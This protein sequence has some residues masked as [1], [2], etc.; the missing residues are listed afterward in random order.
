MLTF[1]EIQQFSSEAAINFTLNLTAEERTRSRHRFVSEEGENVCL[2]LPRGV[3]LQDGDILQDDTQTYLA[4]VIAKPEQVLT[5]YA[6]QNINL[7]KAAYH[8]GNRHVPLE[9]T[10]NYL[11]LSPDPVLR[12]MLQSFELEIKEEVVPFQPE[13]GAYGNYAQHAH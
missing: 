2:R 8:L 9:I 4:K 11:R 5:V 3:V 7:I 12:K 6:S 1:N 10:T 13:K